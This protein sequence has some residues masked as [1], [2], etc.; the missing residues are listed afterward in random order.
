[1][2]YIPF[3]TTR[4]VRQTIRDVK[5]MRKAYRKLLVIYVADKF[6]CFTMLTVLNILSYSGQPAAARQSISYCLHALSL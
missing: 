5:G 6:S 2:A 1:M 4:I 3:I